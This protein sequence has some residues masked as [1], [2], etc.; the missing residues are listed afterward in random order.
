MGPLKSLS[1]ISL[2]LIAGC[3]SHNSNVSQKPLSVVFIGDSITANWVATWAGD[4]FTS[5]PN[6]INK[7]VTGDNSNQVRARFQTDVIALHPDVVVIL[8]GTNDVYPGWNLGASEVPAVFLNAIDS[9]AN[10]ESMVNAAQAAGI[11][12][13]LGTIPPW[14]CDAPNCA[15]AK[16][17]DP[18]VSRFQR[19]ELW[20][21]WLK[22][23]AFSKGIQVADYHSVLNSSAQSDQMYVPALTVDGVHPTSAGYAAM[24]PLVEKTITGL[25]N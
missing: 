6:W 4:T 3:A 5:H 17:A 13:I 7:G 9:P 19:I 16:K 21:E 24:A 8:A 22:G 12:V 25:P 20:N 15:L 18:T 10:M 1:F 2:L 23:Y 14:N 11:R